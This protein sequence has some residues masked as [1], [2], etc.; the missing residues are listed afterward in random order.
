MTDK[1]FSEK[2]AEIG[3][4]QEIKNSIINR[5]QNILNNLDE[6]YIFGAKELGKRFCK[7]FGESGIKVA[8]FIDNNSSKHNQDYCG[9]KIYSIDSLLKKKDDAVIVIASTNYLY[10]IKNQLEKLEFK[11]VIPCQIF[12]LIDKNI[13]KPEPSFDGIVEDIAHNKQK[14]LNFYNIL[15]DKKSKEVLDTVVNFR[16]NH[17]FSLYSKICSENQYFGEPFIKFSENDIFIDGGAFDGDTALNFI[18]KTDNKFKKILFFEPDSASF[19]K[20]QQNLKDCKNIEFFQKGLYSEEKTFKF[21]S[22]GNLGSNIDDDGDTEI[23]VISID[24]V[25][26]EK[27]NYIKMDIE[28]AELE[29][30]KGAKNQLIQGTQ[31]AISLY[32]KSWDIWEIPEYIKQIN[33][34]YRF[35]IRH[36][37]N[38][39][40]ETVLYAII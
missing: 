5:Y 34:N 16:L 8:G 10:E 6:V 15:E 17:D 23:K 24:E 27:A 26:K 11:K 29:A 33:P 1:I 13:Y 20:A 19:F 18:K 36:Y 7:F 28:G 25:L 32:H 40:F 39:I 30:L 38:S 37:T 4:V 14:Y 35:Y 31:L 9:Y 3:S 22:L 2:I 21:N 12:Y